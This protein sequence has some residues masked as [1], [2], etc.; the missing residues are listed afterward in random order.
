M[1][2]WGHEEEYAAQTFFNSSLGSPTQF[3]LRLVEDS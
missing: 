1:Q 2:V 3:S